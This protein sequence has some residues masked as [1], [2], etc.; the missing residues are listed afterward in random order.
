MPCMKTKRD[1]PRVHERAPL[2]ILFGDSNFFYGGTRVTWLRWLEWCCGKN[3]NV[4]DIIKADL[5]AEGFKVVRF[6]AHDWK[7]F[8]DKHAMIVTDFTAHHRGRRVAVLW[9]GQNDAHDASRASAKDPTDHIQSFVEHATNNIQWFENFWNQIDV[10]TMWV[11]PVDDEQSCFTEVY[12]GMV[13]GLNEKIKEICPD[14]HIDLKPVENTYKFES[15]KFHFLPET[16]FKI[17]KLIY[18][19]VHEL[20]QRDPVL[21]KNS[22]STSVSHT[23]RCS[24]ANSCCSC[25]G[26]F[27]QDCVASS[28]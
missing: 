26:F 22:K 5:E 8:H 1:P 25:V 19:S 15:D 24:N 6:R 21:K 14:N 11:L 13:K 17:A 16:R 12:V 10:E 28:P 20:L 4:A 27:V 2:I 9:V 23:L 18:R 3:P 7:G